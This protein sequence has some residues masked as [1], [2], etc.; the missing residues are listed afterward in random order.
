MKLK[1]YVSYTGE[2]FKGNTQ[3]GYE[4]ILSYDE[5]FKNTEDAH[6]KQQSEEIGKLNIRDGVDT[7][8][9]LNFVHDMKDEGVDTFEI[10]TRTDDDHCVTE[11]LLVAFIT[12]TIQLTEEEIRYQYFLYVCTI[13]RRNIRSFQKFEYEYNQFL[14]LKEKFS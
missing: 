4:T 14:S 13:D 1:K 10:T 6:Y 2:D 11:E 12:A 7:D 9:M 5:W 8:T 3:E